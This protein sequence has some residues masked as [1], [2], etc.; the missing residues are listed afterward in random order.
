[1]ELASD[2]RVR[3]T[4]SH[5]WTMHPYQKSGIPNKRVAFL[6]KEKHSATREERDQL[7]RVFHTQCDYELVTT[8]CPQV[9]GKTCTLSLSGGFL[10]IAVLVPRGRAPAGVL[11]KITVF[12]LNA[13]SCRPRKPSCAAP[14]G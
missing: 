12:T 11:G 8:D 3:V 5:E 1:M 6:T 9:K 7:L 2:M 14:W 13:N 4:P 10:R